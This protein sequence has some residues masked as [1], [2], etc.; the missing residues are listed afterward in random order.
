MRCRSS[1]FHRSIPWVLVL[2]AS[3]AEPAGGERVGT[4]SSDLDAPLPEAFCEAVV[5]GVGTVDTETDYLPHLVQCE[6]GAADLEALKV[7]A[8]AARSVLYHA[9]GTSGSI[10]D[11]TSCQVY[12]CGK[13]PLPIHQQAVD[14]TSGVYLAYNGNVTYAAYRAGDP[15]TSAPDCVGGP[16]ETSCI[17][18]NEGKTGTDVEQT[19]S[20][21]VHDPSDAG[22]GTNRGCMSQNGSQ[23]LEE[24]LG[25]DWIEILQFYYGEDIELIQAPGSCV[26]PLPGEGGGGGAGGSIATGGTG[27]G[28]AVVG[29]FGGEGGEVG[30]GGSPPPRG[31][32][33]DEDEGCGCRAA[34][35]SSG[36]SSLPWLALLAGLVAIRRRDS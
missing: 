26:L 34:G 33:S 7:Q 16:G 17:T 21:F 27:V 5:D 22:Y 32:P 9:L 12:S 15:N 8:V 10:C 36:P 24:E 18:Y 13:T 11:S 1:A 2:A 3:C 29:G 30:I 23:C 19:S 35:S 6:N 20:L 4:A 14:E 25:Y 28:G 31:L